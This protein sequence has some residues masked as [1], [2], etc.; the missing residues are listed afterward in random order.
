M[1]LRI[2]DES[3]LEQRLAWFR[4]ARFGM[5]IHWG[6]YAQLGRHEWAMNLE[7]I[8]LAEYEKLADTWHPKPNAARHWAKLAKEAGQRYMVMTTKHHEGFCLFDTK[9]TDY[10]AVKRGPGRDL[11][12]E[13]VEAARAEGLKVGF[14]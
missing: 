5:F 1:T 6:L 3:N 8:P 10:N 12:A 4:A 11:V 2:T 13:Y 9:Y 7:R 14:Y